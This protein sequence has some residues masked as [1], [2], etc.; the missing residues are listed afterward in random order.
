MKFSFRHFLHKRILLNVNMLIAY[1]LRRISS[2]IWGRQ[3]YLYFLWTQKTY[4]SCSLDGLNRVTA[5]LNI[6]IPLICCGYA[7]APL[8]LVH[9][10]LCDCLKRMTSSRRNKQTF[11]R[12]VTAGFN[13][14][15]TRALSCLL[16][17][18]MPRSK[19]VSSAALA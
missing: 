19:N 13:G 2:Q 11:H 9:Y 8:N 10:V 14:N 16:V 18:K 5:I 15:Y 3:S 1:L 6:D 17:H 12:S 4:P 7:N